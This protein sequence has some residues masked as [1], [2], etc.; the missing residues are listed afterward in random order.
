MEEKSTDKNSL[1]GFL[2]IG[3]ILFGYFFYQEKFGPKP[4]E[5]KIEE[6]VAIEES[7]AAITASISDTNAI[8]IDSFP[9]DS[10]VI[11]EGLKNKFGGFAAHQAQ[12]QQQI[13]TVETDLLKIQIDALGGIIKSA[14]LKNYNTFDSI[15]VD[16]YYNNQ[17]DYS[18]KFEN[19]GRIINTNEIVFSTEGK[20]DVHLSGNDSEEIRLVAKHENGQ[21]IEIV[22][23]FKG[24]SYGVNY[25]TTF[26]NLAESPIDFAWKGTLRQSEK[27]KDNELFDAGIYYRLKADNSTDDVT[28]A[29]SDSENEFDGDINWFGFKQQFFTSFLVNESGF[30]TKEIKITPSKDT[31]L[32]L[33]ELEVQATLS[34]ENVMMQAYPME[35]YFSPL[36]YDLLAEQEKNFEDVV[37]YG[38]GLFEFFNVYF[39]LPVVKTMA[40]WGWNFGLIIFMVALLVKLLVSPFTYKTYLSSMKMRVLKPELDEIKEKFGDD[41]QKVQQEQFKLY[42]KAGVNPLGGCIPMLFQMPILFAMFRFFPSSLELRGQSFLWAS[43]LSS[44][45]SVLDL[46]FDIPFYGDHVSLFC[47]L[48][49]VSTILSTKANTQQMPDSGNG[50]AAQQMKMMQYM[51]PIMFLGMFNSYAC[52]LSI[53]YTCMN[54][55]TMV[56]QYV[57][58]NFIIDEDKIHAQIKER[59]KAPQKKSGFRAKLDELMEQ[60]QQQKAR[61]GK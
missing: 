1:I 6:T 36:D 17:N 26:N 54:C 31:S 57:I 46:G 52:A 37:P 8:L 60:Q 47:L 45:D 22:Y 7:Q 16:L 56:Q 10:V 4:E 24:N 58:K 23:G 61:K 51:M 55:L 5:T 28:G 15:P 2:L 35:F 14:V 38:W 21:K 49:T 18:Y 53:Y 13:I 39:T 40:D 43:D 12:A 20:T 41:A 29:T 30:K 3:I 42:G 19:Q 50:M 32:V 59:Q 33:T 44:Y 11:T 9:S 27:S 25:H 34:D 48:M